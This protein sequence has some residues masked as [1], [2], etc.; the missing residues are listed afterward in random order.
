MEPAKLNLDGINPA[1]WTQALD[2]CDA[3]SDDLYGSGVA[4]DPYVHVGSTYFCIDERTCA[5]A[6]TELD[7]SHAHWRKLSAEEIISISERCL[8]AY[9]SQ[10][11]L[12]QLDNFVYVFSHI[13]HLGVDY[14]STAEKAREV[15]KK[16]QENRAAIPV[17]S[18]AEW[19]EVVKNKNKK[20]TESLYVEEVDAANWDDYTPRQVINLTRQHYKSYSLEDLEELLTAL[21]QFLMS[22]SG[23][24]IVRIDLTKLIRDIENYK[25]SARF[26]GLV[27]NV[28]AALGILESMTRGNTLAAW[29]LKIQYGTFHLS[30]NEALNTE[31]ALLK[32]RLLHQLHL[33]IHAKCAQPFHEL[34][35][36]AATF[37]RLLVNRARLDVS[38]IEKL[39]P[40]FKM[41]PFYSED[42]ALCKLL[43]DASIRLSAIDP[44]AANADDGRY[45]AS[46]IEKL[47]PMVRMINFA[48][49]CK[50]HIE[51]FKPVL[52]Q[53]FNFEMTL[54]E[55]FKE[56]KRIGDS[57]PLNSEYALQRDLTR[58]KKLLR[59]F[60][61]MCGST[62]ETFE[63][64]RKAYR[65]I[66]LELRPDRNPNAKDI[67]SRINSCYS[68]I[69]TL[70]KNH[71]DH[72]F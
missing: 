6:F 44:H 41:T 7:E 27:D 64:V 8:P 29:F 1:Q 69:E 23:D 16:V 40:S 28:H 2:A 68:E 32:T 14:R 71:P 54:E 36:E 10:E 31:N 58:F 46:L 38:G 59:K 49:H 33:S 50:Y 5:V 51:D 39:V 11:R 48:C 52:K 26:N 61:N 57:Y 3:A 18:A 24:G 17:L 62:A 4:I 35:E 19:M 22:L 43:A 21:R 34:K 60:N 37:L 63:E 42:L 12:Q 66:T 15:R 67:C 9:K 53:V 55:F 45:V 20:E 56:E 72:P 25:D 70:T 13:E 30:L 47:R 65:K